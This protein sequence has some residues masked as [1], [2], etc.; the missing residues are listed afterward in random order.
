M[1]K[2]IWIALLFVLN[3]AWIPACSSP[4]K[5]IKKDSSAEEQRERR[6]KAMRELDREIP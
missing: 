3:I 5:V 2:A 4:E 1:K 6:D